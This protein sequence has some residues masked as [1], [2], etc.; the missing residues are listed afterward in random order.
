MEVVYCALIK[1]E[2]EPIMTFKNVTITTKYSEKQVI[3]VLPI[4]ISND[5]KIPVYVYEQT[6][7]NSML[8]LTQKE[9]LV[10]FGIM[11][12]LQVRTSVGSFLI[13]VLISVV[14]CIIVIVGLVFYFL[15][16]RYVKLQQQLF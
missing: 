16:K 5:F 8:Y 11:H 6:D 15:K 7:V 13:P 9:E 1:T 2:K 3:Q 14:V 10:F 12:I 4:A